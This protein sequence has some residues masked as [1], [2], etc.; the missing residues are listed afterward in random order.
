MANAMLD[1]RQ[2][3]GAS[4]RAELITGQAAPVD[5]G[6]EGAVKPALCQRITVSGW[7]IFSAFSTVGDGR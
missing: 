1:A 2:E 7:R 4:R 3:D 6:G 5:G